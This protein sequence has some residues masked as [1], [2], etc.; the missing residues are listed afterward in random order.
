RGA[1]R[2]ISDS[3]RDCFELECRAMKRV[4]DEMGLTNVEI[5]IPFVR[6]VGEAKQVVE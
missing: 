2:Y 4:R 5:M 6:T 1:S 3:F